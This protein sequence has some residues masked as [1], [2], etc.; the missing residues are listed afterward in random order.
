M[1]RDG[2]FRETAVWRAGEDGYHT[3]RIPALFV[4]RRGALL[5]FCEGRRNSRS[6]TGDIDLLIKR[7][8]DGGRTWSRQEVVADFGPDT[9]GN[10][11]PVQDRKT[12]IIWMPLTS[13][14]GA[15]SEKEIRE[16]PQGPTRTVWL[17]D[18]RDDGRHWTKP[19][20]ITRHAK[21]PNW[22]WYATGPGIG[23]QLRS[24][25]MVIPCDHNVAGTRARHSHIIYSDDSGRTWRLGG[26]LG[27]HTNECQVVELPNG[28]LLMNMRSYHGINRRAI[29][30]SRDGGLT[31]SEVTFEEALIEPVCQAAFVK[32]AGR[33]LLFSNPASTRRERMTVRMSEDG[34]ATWPVERVVWEGPAAYS[35]LGVLADRSIGLLYERGESSPYEQIVFVRFTER[36]LRT[37]APQRPSDLAELVK[38]DATIRLD[39]RY[40]KATN[41][42]GKPVYQEERAFLQRPAAEA[43]VRAHRSLREKGYGLLVFDGYRPWG[44]TKLFWDLTPP[45]KR[46]FVADPRKGSKHNRGCAVDLTLFELATGKEVEMPSGYDEMTERAYPRYKG[47]T[48]AQREAR[49]LLIRAMEAEGFQVE[50]NE[51]WHYNY[52]NWRS[53]PVQDVPFPR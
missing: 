36:W 16:S 1:G 29:A 53:Y 37:P 21:D 39:V 22:T 13:N 43:L 32:F 52:R 9:I 17:T 47:A 2:E 34:G 45:S 14:P 15:A 30:R 6:D 28:D 42:L 4:T 41:F 27:E 24:G 38:L 8:E 40:A 46:E 33:R 26:V 51:W 7:S 19:V 20:E 31:W 12:G 25:R 48:T 44:V 5:A 50:A 11:C 3:Y 23:I 10:P 35:S 49:D 18:S